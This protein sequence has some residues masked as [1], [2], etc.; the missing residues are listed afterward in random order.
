MQ[1]GSA[2][3]LLFSPFTV[4]AVT[5]K[6]RIVSSAH[7]TV[8]AHDGHVTDQLIAYHRARAEGGVGLIV[9]QAS[10]VHESARYTSHVLM[11]ADDSCIPGFARVADAVHPHGV[12]LFA[13]LFHPG[14]EIMEGQD[15]SLPVATHRPRCRPIGSMWCRGRCRWT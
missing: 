1:P 14:R 3:P 13:Q 8:M 5:V 9:L 6:N 15:G 2:F 12:T 11:A 7:D 4:N 10:G